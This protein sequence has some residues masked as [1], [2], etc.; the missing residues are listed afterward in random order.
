MKRTLSALA[1]ALLGV[2]AH[3]HGPTPQK[4][5]ISVRIAAPPARVWAA[6]A[7]FAGIAAWNPAIGKSSADRGNEAGSTRTLTLPAGELTEQ[8]D[9]YDA[10]GMSMSYRS[11][12]PDPKVLPASSYSG[13]LSVRPD[14]DASKLVWQARG[15]RADT[16]NE[17][18]AGMDDDSAVKALK[19]LMTPGLEAVRAKIEAGGTP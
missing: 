14:G 11:G 19:A 17:P 13:R 8:L 2:A 7:D 18:A 4:I 9:E 5:D 3:A 15:Y 6:V 10:A 16:G 1:L 12:T